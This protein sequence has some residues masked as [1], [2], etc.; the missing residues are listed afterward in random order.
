MLGNAL[1][2]VV[3]VDVVGELN[4][5]DRQAGNGFRADGGQAGRAVDGIL[6]RLGDKLLDLLGGEARRLGLDIH[7]R[8]HK[9]R[10][11]IQRRRPRRPDAQRQRDQGQGRNGAPE[12]HAQ[13]DKPAHGQSAA[14]VEGFISRA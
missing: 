1:A 4:G 10:K 13:V 12:T 8:R 6:D 5:D 11:D 14:S 7:R 9:F 3:E 2:G